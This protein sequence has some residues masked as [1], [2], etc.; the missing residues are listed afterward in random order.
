MGLVRRIRGGLFLLDFMG[1]LFLWVYVYIGMDFGSIL[2]YWLIDEFICF[3]LNG[4]IFLMIYLKLK[5][6]YWFFFLKNKLKEYVF[7]V[8]FFSWILGYNLEYL[9]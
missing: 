6:E 8:V 1:I 5:L 4:M 9:G 3:L 7:F 2:F